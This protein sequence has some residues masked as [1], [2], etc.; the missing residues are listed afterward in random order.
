MYLFCL[1]KSV[2]IAPATGRDAWREHRASWGCRPHDPPARPLNKQLPPLLTCHL[3]SC[4]WKHNVCRQCP[5]AIGRILPTRPSRLLPGPAKECPVVAST[6]WFGKGRFPFLMILEQQRFELPAWRSGL[7]IAGDASLAGPWLDASASGW[8]GGGGCPA[9]ASHG[10]RPFSSQL[11][12]DSERASRCQ[13]R[14]GSVCVC[15]CARVCACASVC[16]CV[17]VC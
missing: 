11:C 12:L 3:E 6:A 15:A 10:R 13:A 4:F 8:G 2:Q 14:A 16:V 7:M 5:H 9:A 1:H 17:C